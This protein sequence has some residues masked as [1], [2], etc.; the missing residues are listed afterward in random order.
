MFNSQVDSLLLRIAKYDVTE[1]RRRRVVHVE[2]GMLGPGDGVYCA[3]DQ[4]FS[5]WGQYLNRSVLEQ[6]SVG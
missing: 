2:N 4:V 6:G 3:S 5:G 1:S